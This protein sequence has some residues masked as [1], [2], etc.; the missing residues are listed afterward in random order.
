MDKSSPIRIGMIS[1]EDFENFIGPSFDIY[2]TTRLSIAGGKPLVFGWNWLAFL[3]LPSWLIY[4][5]QYDLAAGLFLI[6]VL[7]ILV[8]VLVPAIAPLTNALQNAMSA[9]PIG[10][11]LYGRN[12]V[13]YRSVSVIKKADQLQ[14]Q[15]DERSA[16]LREKG[17]TDVFGAWVAP[18]LFFAAIAL[19]V[20]L[21]GFFLA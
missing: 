18:F 15:G 3:M 20:I 11:A 9:L 10:A 16:F 4:R 8:G 5:R 14:L 19:V 21:I 7:P 17:S 6:V 13:V 1:K 2:E 12:L